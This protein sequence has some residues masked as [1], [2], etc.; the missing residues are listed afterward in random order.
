MRYLGFIA[1]LACGA[2]QADGARIGLEYELEKNRKTVVMNDAFTLKP[3][4]EFPK[5]SP[6]NLV[7]L[8]IDRNRDRDADSNGDQARET[9][10][11]VRLRHSGSFTDTLGYYIRGGVGRSMNN[12]ENFSTPTSRLG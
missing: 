12:E 2:A 11:F 4:W 6:I 3:G 8:L 10:L 9:K 1:L 7:E 5:G